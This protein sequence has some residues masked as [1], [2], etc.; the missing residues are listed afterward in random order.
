MDK[1]YRIIYK[2]GA[3]SGPVVRG[4]AR[5]PLKKGRQPNIFYLKN[6]VKLRHFGL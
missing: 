1:H 5:Q 2:S 3:D 6:L 4:G